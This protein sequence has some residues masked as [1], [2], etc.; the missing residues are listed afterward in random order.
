MG[1]AMLGTSS[2]VTA[3]VVVWMVGAALW[4]STAVSDVRAAR[5]FE[6][7]DDEDLVLVGAVT[8]GDVKA[9]MRS[10]WLAASNN[11]CKP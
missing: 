5:R 3:C 7:A 4:G 9:S 2:S 10:I 8:E 6:R 11:A 1:V